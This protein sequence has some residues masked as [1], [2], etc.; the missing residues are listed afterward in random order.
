MRCHHTVDIPATK[1]KKKKTVCTKRQGVNWGE[2]CL[3]EK[4]EGGEGGSFFRFTET[5]PVLIKN[6]FHL[7]ST[8]RTDTPGMRT[9]TAV[10]SL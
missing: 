2:G 4:R 8:F 6:T 1:V 5:I 3:E 7:Q 10:V 9:A